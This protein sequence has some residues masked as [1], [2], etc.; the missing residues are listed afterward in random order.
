MILAHCHSA[1]IDPY[2]ISGAVGLA[3]S[4]VQAGSEWAVGTTSELHPTTVVRL[5]DALLDA[6]PE[7]AS[8]E[9]MARVLQ[10]VEHRLVTEG[11]LDAG[12][13]RLWVR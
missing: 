11:S 7:D 1:T 6:Y 9:S 8:V 5:V 4:Y 12:K 3:Q 2:G 10:R 13:L